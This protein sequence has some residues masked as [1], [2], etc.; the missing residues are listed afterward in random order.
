MEK[1]QENNKAYLEIRNL[2]QSNENSEQ[3]LE[4][5]KNIKFL[6]V[7]QNEK[8]IN[9]FE[10]VQFENLKF[11]LENIEHGNSIKIEMLNMKSECICECFLNENRS[12][13]I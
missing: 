4:I 5:K 7:L 9:K 1:S 13:G 11:E 3:I 12:Q 8:E 10:V 2:I 6:R